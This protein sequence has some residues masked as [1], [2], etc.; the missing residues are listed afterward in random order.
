MQSFEFQ[1]AVEAPLSTIF[2]LYSNLEWWRSRSIFSDVRWVQGEPWEE[3]SRMRL[4][5]RTPVK[6]TVDHVILE[7]NRGESAVYLSHVLGITCETRVKFIARSTTHTTIQV[8]MQLLGTV[9]RM[10]GFALEPVIEKSTR[11][12]FEDL[13]R[14]SEA[15]A[16]RAAASGD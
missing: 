13:R 9:S 5:S 7:F 11:S 10:L 12:F 14:D 15:E 8:Q 3:G 16:R 1:V 4:E 6:A 2:S